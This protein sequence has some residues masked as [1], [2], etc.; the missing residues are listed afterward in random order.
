MNQHVAIRAPEHASADTLDNLEAEASLLGALLNDNRLF[1][2]A[3]DIVSAPDFS[4]PLHQRIYAVALGETMSGRPANPVTLRGHFADDPAI[5]DVGGVAYLAKLTA[6]VFSFGDARGLAQHV[7][8]LSQRRSMRDQ[9]L[10]AAAACADM[11][12][13][14][15]GIA[16]LATTAVAD[17]AVDG[18]VEASG[19]EC[20]EQHMQALTQGKH[21]VVSGDI[22]ALDELLGPLRPG[23]LLICAGRPGMGKT[24][25]AVS[26]AL[27]AARRGHGTL[28]VSLEM[29]ASELGA[30][31][32]SNR[33]FGDAHDRSVPYS[34]IVDG[35]LHPS[36][37]RSVS[38]AAH[39]IEQWPFMVADIGSLTMGRL[40]RMVRR[41]ARRFEARGAK[42][43]LVIIDYLQLLRTDQVMRS[44]YEAI[45]EISR[46]LKAIAKSTGVTIMALA[47]LS[48]EVEKRPDKRPVLS[49]LRDSGQIEQDADAVLFLLRQEYYLAQ[50]KPH[51]ASPKFLE[52]EAQMEGE[53]DR[54][55]FILAKRRNGVIGT[56]TA[57]FH[58]AYQ[59][60]RG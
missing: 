35:R 41:H 5:K 12:S 1:D 23:Q 18:L 27:G 13:S 58:G 24:A 48:R 43:E 14:I 25:L 30:R 60:V 53:R 26:Y 10:D 22:P 46:S 11:G 31:M 6:D 55:E 37:R 57:E 49:D 39:E 47:Q 21:G 29:S 40:E 42:L 50:I 56:A 32:A 20:I 3:A 52:W 59:A 9:L 4:E 45:S 7:R 16:D 17:R 54:I 2:M 19:G 38:Q 33:I 8:D 34:C 15:N 44:A 51:D 36:Q 28:F